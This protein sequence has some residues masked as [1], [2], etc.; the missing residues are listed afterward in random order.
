M[1]RNVSTPAMGCLCGLL[2]LMAGC[3]QGSA[4]KTANDS[5][6][7]GKKRPD[8]E[9][10]MSVLYQ[11]QAAEYRALCLQAYNI[12]KSKVLRSV[13]QS[14]PKDSFAVIT[15]LDE[16]ALDNS[17]DEAQLI[18]DSTTYTQKSFDEWARAEKAKAVPGSVAFFNFVN[19]LNA[20]QRKK[21]DIYYV[22][23]RDS[24]LTQVTMDNMAEL[25]FPQL[26]RS[27]FLFQT[28]RHHPSKEGRRQQIEKNHTVIL[29]LG[30]NLIDLDST[31]DS[32]HHLTE[33][34][35]RHRVDSLAD[36]FG[37]KYIVFPNAIYGD[38]EGALYNYHYPS[39][40]SVM[41]TRKDSLRGYR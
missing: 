8:A 6:A 22:S 32:H 21:I 40:D 30:D 18:L 39:L 29:L 17:A 1:K 14:T 20:H 41:Q 26:T 19:S 11:Q 24:A 16:T 25:G 27:H 31:F 5:V 2:L 10:I 7:V 33:G 34:E 23:N 15:D 9:V 37:D 28:D 12:A 36:Y 38:W 4:G 35:R 3:D 13:N